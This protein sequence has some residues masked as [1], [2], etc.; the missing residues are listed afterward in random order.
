DALTSVLMFR[1]LGESECK[2]EEAQRI[3][4][5]GHWERD[6]DTDA[7]TWSDETYRIFGLRPQER[8]FSFAEFGVLIHP[9][10]RQMVAEAA[11]AL[12]GNQRYDVEYRVVRPNGEV[13]LVHA[14]G[15]LVTDDAGRPRRRFGTVQDITERKRAEQRLM[16]QHTVTQTLAEAATLEEATPKI[17]Q[18]VCEC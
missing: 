14:Q 7:V 15:A 12:R 5:V 8:G 4:H 11:A 13:R 2:L 9:D 17:L 16:A 10:D 3:A 6:V 18:A 1:N